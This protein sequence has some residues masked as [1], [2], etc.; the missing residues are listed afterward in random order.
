METR[1]KH[2]V[3]VHHKKLLYYYYFL[4]SVLLKECTQPAEYINHQHNTNT[5]YHSS[6]QGTVGF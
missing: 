4:H 1:N 3:P 5:N 6:I 2:S